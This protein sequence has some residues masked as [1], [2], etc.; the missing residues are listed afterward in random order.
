M[1]RFLRGVG[2]S[3]YTLRRWRVV[4]RQNIPASGGIIIAANHNSA[5]DP[6]LLGC[7]IN[8]EVYF[9]S[10]EE[11]FQT[12]LLSW[13]F[14]SVH[15]FPVK[16][17]AVDRRAIRHALDLLA[18]GK[19]LGIFPEGTRVDEGKKVQPHSGVAMLALKAKVPVVP[20][21]LA[22]SVPG[23]PPRALIGQPI[24][25]ST[26]YEMKMNSALLDTISREIMERIEGLPAKTNQLEAN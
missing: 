6:I 21:A 7:A 11:L 19:V 14:T 26:Y 23:E 8:R 22:G 16:R 17:G 10:K 5:W 2:R 12:R 24:D 3:I 18:S 4:G 13:F 25:L 1:Y 15:A 20:V 9:M